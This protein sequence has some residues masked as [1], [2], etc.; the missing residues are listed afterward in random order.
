MTT[1]DLV[2]PLPT[3]RFHDGTKVAYDVPRD[4]MDPRYTPCTDH[5]P[6]CDC[7][8]AEFA[9][10]IGELRGEL[11]GIAKAAREVLRGHPIWVDEG[12][13]NGPREV[14]CRCTGCQIV[15]AGFVLRHSEGDSTFRDETDGLTSWQA[16]AEQRWKVCFGRCPNLDEHLTRAPGYGGYFT[17]D[18]GH[19]H[20]HLHHGGGELV[21][22]DDPNWAPW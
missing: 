1:T 19:F 14:G 16:E 4:T 12:G 18:R 5:H 13:P 8:E 7:R 11:K 17:R 2:G 9:E 21:R 15:R 10:E 22:E 6:A 20:E 3:I